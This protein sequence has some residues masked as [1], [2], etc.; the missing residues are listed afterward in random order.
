M[1]PLAL[2]IVGENLLQPVRL[3]LG[4]RLLRNCG[5]MKHNE[6]FA[7]TITAKRAHLFEAFRP[8]QRLSLFDRH[9]VH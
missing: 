8:L 7:T 3:P 6:L 1:F 2:V 4:G 5:I 9:C